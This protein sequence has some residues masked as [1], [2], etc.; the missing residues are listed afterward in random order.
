MTNPF[1]TQR[2]GS[3]GVRGLSVPAANQQTGTR[4]HAQVIDPPGQ[5]FS[6]S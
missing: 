4:N 3:T 6:G 1:Q 5:D 2:V